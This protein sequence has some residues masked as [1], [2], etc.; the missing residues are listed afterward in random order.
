M[1]WCFGN[2]TVVPIVKCIGLGLGLCIWGSSNMLIGW[3][4][5]SFGILGV[6]KTTVAHPSMNYAGVALAVV[7]M[8]IFF[9]IKSEGG[10]VKKAY[11]K[12]ADVEDPGLNIYGA[13]A[14]LLTTSL[15]AE[16]GAAEDEEEEESW[17]DKLT[18]ATKKIVGLGGALLAGCLY[19][20][21]FNPPSYAK[22]HY[23]YPNHT[24]QMK[25]LYSYVLPH[26]CGIFV[27]STMF[28]VAYCIVKR[29]TPKVYPQVTF[30]AILS[31]MCGKRNL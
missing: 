24:A 3:A 7:S 29:N 25:N 20:T 26:F 28:L 21:N 18:P 16:H 15:N 9:F 8:I 2:V 30:P 6:T 12:V 17:T 11:H 4:S 23:P 19:G 10:N 13:N 5:G 27:T 22:E 14:G 1:I 31:G